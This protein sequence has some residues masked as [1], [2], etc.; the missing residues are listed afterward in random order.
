MK[1]LAIL[2]APVLW[3][4]KND[5]IRFNRSFYRNVFFCAASSGLFLFLST[6]MLN[7]GMTRLQSLSPDVFRILLIKGYSLFFMIIFF[8]Q[9]VNGI[10]ISFNTYYQSK[11]MEILLTSPIGRTPLF[12]SRL[13][14]THMR[15]SWMLVVFGFPLLV[16]CGLLYHANLFYYV[17]ALVLFGAFSTLSVNIG[18]GLTIILSSIF[19]VRRLKKMF[20]SGGV[21]VV[22]FLVIL[23]RV[24]KP[25][26]LVNPE[27]FANLALFINEM[28]RPSFILLPNRWLSESLFNLLGNAFNANT[29]IYV[30]LLVLTAYV[31]TVLSMVTFGRYHYRG[32][33]LLQEGGIIHRKEALL[34]SPLTRLARKIACSRPV[35]TLSRML[36]EESRTMI[37]KDFLF[38]IRDVKTVHQ[39]IIVLS[40]I[41]IYLLSVA[42]LP[43][44]WEGYAVQL[45][46]LISFF[47]LG[48]I[49][50][51]VA[52]LCSRL[53]YPAVTSE[54]TSLWMVKTSPI[55][56]K[57]YIVTKYLFFVIPIVLIGQLL[58]ISSSL[59]IGVDGTFTLLK[60]VTTALLSLSLSGLAVFFGTSD[61]RHARSETHRTEGR[62]ESTA[63][64]LVSLFLI[65]FTLA[66]EIAPAFLYF[67][68]ESQMSGF[69]TKAWLV[70]GGTT[71]FLLLMNLSVTVFS[72]R[73]SIKK[74]EELQV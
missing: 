54:G 50:I 47:N 9:M 35:Q 32:W 48:L 64:M 4:V 19:H 11:E 67:L 70:I 7:I 8:S 63:F 58:A 49:L 16:S 46:Y 29:L 36:G 12:F 26:R 24:F 20:F 55:T 27:L 38:Q 45:K 73:L 15:A 5:V 59:M 60:S 40:L 41:I 66:L 33:A 74:V 10:V 14:E 21:V 28:K 39:M 1:G 34:D 65:F 30:S 68:K 17:Y 37:M 44:N 62:T 2:M 25:E 13:L 53:V 57:R 51:I 42:A 69:T 18:V 22:V 23:M 43:L 52:S 56:P 71:I 61:M 31:T 72:L 6:K 3:S